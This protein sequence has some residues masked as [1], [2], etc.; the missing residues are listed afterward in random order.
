MRDKSR[1]K[2]ITLTISMIVSILALILTVQLTSYISLAPTPINFETP[3]LTL[4]MATPTPTFAPT[5]SPTPLP[6]L[7]SVPTPTPTS[8]P[9]ST[10]TLTTVPQNLPTQ[11][12]V[13]QREV[14]ILREEVDSLA[15]VVA[16]NPD[17][18]GLRT[19]LQSLDGRIS[20]IE[21]AIL[22]NPARALQLTLLSQEMDN[23]KS[24]Y[25]SDLEGTRREIERIY[26]LNK[27]FIGLMFTM[28][29]GLLSLAVSNF[30][31]KPEKPRERKDLRRR[32]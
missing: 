12:A 7:T 22:D 20:I 4:V 10:P 6:T 14:A 5:L 8:T 28:A 18:N 19:D 21:Q 26:D 27:W 23:L 29:I 32:R 11:V 31:K 1:L 2:T 17:F 16:S 24:R 25:E 13:L 9:R 30:I 3:T 15:Q